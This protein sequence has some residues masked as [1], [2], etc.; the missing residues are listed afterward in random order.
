MG[1]GVLLRRFW[2]EFAE[3]PEIEDPTVITDILS[4]LHIE[5]APIGSRPSRDEQNRIAHANG[6]G[7][8][9]RHFWRAEFHNSGP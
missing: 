6:R 5:S 7:G 2:A 1:R 4:H 3:S 9:A 8:A